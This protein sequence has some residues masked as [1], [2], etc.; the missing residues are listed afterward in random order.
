MAVIH[1]I[2][3]SVHNAFYNEFYSGVNLLMD[4]F[5]FSY[6]SIFVTMLWYY[7]GYVTCHQIVQI[8]FIR[9]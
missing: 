4:C 8:S 9:L 6:L 3:A 5:S 7:L 2:L 1:V